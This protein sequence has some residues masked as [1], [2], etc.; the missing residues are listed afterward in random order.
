MICVRF[1]NFKIY[2]LSYEFSNQSDFPTTTIQSYYTS[3]QKKFL[4]TM[5]ISKMVMNLYSKQ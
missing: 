2:S 3:N 5:F 1:C 4:L